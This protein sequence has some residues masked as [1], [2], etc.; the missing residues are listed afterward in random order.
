MVVKKPAPTVRM[1]LFCGVAAAT[2]IPVAAGARSDQR[3]IRQA[4]RAHAGDGAEL[5]L[6]DRRRR[7][8]I[9]GSLCPACRAFSWKRQ[10]VL[11]VES[12]LNRL[13]IRKGPQEQSGRDQNQQREGDL[14][15][16]Q[17][18]AQAQ[19]AKPVRRAASP[20]RD[21][22]SA[23]I[24]STR[25]DWS[26]GARPNS[27]PVSSESAA[28]TASTCQFN[29]A[30]RVKFS[31]PF[32]SSRV[33]KR[34]P[35]T[36]NATPSA[37]PSRRQ[38]DALGE[39]LA[40]DPKPS[41]AQ[42]QPHRHFALPGSRARQQQVGDVRARD[43]Q[44]QA[45][46]RQQDVQRLRIRPAQAVQSARAFPDHQLGRSS[47]RR[48]GSAVRAHSWN[49]P[50]SAACACARLTPGRSRAIGIDPVV[51][52][53]EVRSRRCSPGPPEAGWRASEHRRP[54]GTVGIDAKEFGRRHADHG[55]GQ[56]V[57]QDRLPER[58]R[59][60]A[61]TALAQREADDGDGRRAGAIVVRRDQPSRRPAERRDRGNS[62]RTRIPCWRVSAWPRNVRLRSPAPW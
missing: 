1:L 20:V 16:H 12:E 49:G 59:R 38:Q 48:F 14:R 39:Q 52:R 55:E 25:V 33:R 5:R 7:S 23:G 47:G 61:E 21:S 3:M 30:R 9:S 31:R 60:S 41:G 17:H 42:A 34:M 35:Q 58:V 15:N 44:D 51:V 43:G 18:A 46:Q 6:A 27:T 62:R 24:K 45:D 40:D 37:P 56:V 10:H 26:A 11:A 29:S 53:V 57:D 13:Q 36:A 19:A 28:T 2:L 54:G 4:C 32:A 8:T 50:A 22:L